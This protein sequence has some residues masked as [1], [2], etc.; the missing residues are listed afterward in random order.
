MTNAKDLC[1]KGYLVASDRF[2]TATEALN[3]IRENKLCERTGKALSGGASICTAIGSFVPG[4]GVLGGALRIGA[5]LLNPKPSLADMKRTQTAIT[6]KISEQTCELRKDFKAIKNEVKDFVLLLDNEMKNID[7]DIS[8]IKKIIVR[9]YSVVLD[10]RYKDGLEKIASAYHNFFLGV[11]N[12]ENT[13]TDLQSFIFELG[14]IAIQSLDPG[15]IKEYIN[16]MKVTLDEDEIHSSLKYI[17]L[18]RSMYLFLSSVYFTYKEDTDRVATEFEKFNNDYNGI[19][20]VFREEMGYTFN[21]NTIPSVKFSEHCEETGQFLTSDTS[22]SE[23]PNKH[24][25]SIDI[26]S[27]D[28]DGKIPL[29]SFD[30]QN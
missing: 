16:A 5:C 1:K 22:C 24:E 4:V 13:L 18:V 11:N 9:T 8:D 23:E 7:N 29:N 3:I 28:N 17:I 19:C 12:L 25:I 21:P 20:K 26:P 15:K 27:P 14:S 10:T 2:T 6:Y 30:K